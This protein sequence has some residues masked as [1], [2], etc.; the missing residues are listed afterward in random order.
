MAEPIHQPHLHEAEED[1]I[2]IK[3]IVAK[4]LSN[5]LLFA[6]SAV[7]CV[8]LALLYVYIAQPEWHTSSKILV[9][10][11]KNSVA[12]AGGSGMNAD[13][14]SLFNVKSSADNEIQI[15]KAR[16]LMTEVVRQ[17]QLNVRTYRKAGL[18]KIELYD[19]APFTVSL[20]YKADTLQPRSYTIKVLDAAH[21]ELSNSKDDINLKARFGDSV[22]LKQYNLVLN[23]VSPA[24]AGE[25]YTISIESPD[26]TIDGFT[27]NF[28]A[29]LSDKQATTID[30]TISYPNPKKGEAILNKLMQVYLERNL[31]NKVAIA[32]STMH[33]IDGRLAIVQHD[34]S[35]V[36]KQFE[37]YKEQHSIA[38][39]SEQSKALVGS[40]SDY[41]K[42]LKDQQLQLSVVNDLEHY[43]NSGSN[44]KVVPSSLIVPTDMS[45]GQ[46]INAYNDLIIARD[47]AG[48]SY[49]E[50]NPVIRNYDQQI[51][52]ARQAL[53]RNVAT[54]KKSLQVG[55]SQLQQQ[56]STFTGQLKSIPSKERGY[57]DFARQQNLKQELYLYLLQKREE[58]AISK[59]S[60]ISSS[61]IIDYAK[62]DF[63]PYK[64]KKSI[65]VLIGLILGLILPGIY[66]FIKELL[67]IRITSKADIEKMST[68]PMIGEISHNTEEKSLVTGVGS[69]S[70][71]SEQFRALRT[72]LQYVL[73][74]RKSNVLLFTSSMS[75]EGKSFLSLNL[76][77]ALGL[78][79]K[80]VVFM[81]MDLR[82]P[83]LSENM[84]LDHNQG[85][86]NYVISGKTDYKQLI[87]PAWF[88]EN[89]YLISAG[90]IP[91][92]PAELL[93]SEKLDQLI[94][95]LKKE[96]D[97]VIIDCAPIGLVTDALMLE[98]YADLTLY[99][100]RQDYT[101]KSQ[102]NIVND[103][104]YNRKVKKMYLIM[105]DIKTQKSGYAA[106]GTGAYGGYG[107]GGYAE[108]TKKKSWWKRLMDS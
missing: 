23:A 31:N 11:Q 25:A 92:N 48:L 1:T 40:A 90:P 71:I 27:T 5:W 63:L 78:I 67:N 61:R 3:Q 51:E 73:D 75:G 69:R 91:P 96:F 59:T 50:N 16:S 49:T 84:G 18:K 95:D 8:V 70:V 46:A 79:G 17:M 57:L 42:K 52:T 54:Y 65:I 77:S 35:D 80:K 43:I 38:D 89:C 24:R 55:I 105:N 68:V 9:E 6:I 62:S 66:L 12:S 103:L 29:A 53:L 85:F 47:R 37:Q 13:F 81:E 104:E 100:V 56:N 88:N 7:V 28:S 4:V 108:E 22:R 45:F 102:L 15:L 76:G 14:S 21:Y 74:Q 10:D 101:Y 99:V 20:H 82:K 106:Y 60:T 86:T 97:Y 72:N 2:D 33:F 64:P 30:L 94:E 36:E 93:M 26:A 19:E 32:D 58:T 39:I 98:K 34:L 87:K 83:K 107:Y 41:Y 44:K